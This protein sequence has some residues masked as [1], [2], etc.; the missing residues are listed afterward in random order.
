MEKTPF[1]IAASGGADRSAT[2]TSD[3]MRIG[4][5]AVPSGSAAKDITPHTKTEYRDAIST[6]LRNQPHLHSMGRPYS[7]V[8]LHVY[9]YDGAP[10]CRR[11]EAHSC[12]IDNRDLA[13]GTT[14]Q[15]RSR[16]A[17]TAGS[18]WAAPPALA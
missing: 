4:R 6:Y 5:A 16:P 17:A 14:R 18:S 13:P 1:T 11:E 10:A 3:R 12:G 8:S 9:C 7:R 15:H 2:E